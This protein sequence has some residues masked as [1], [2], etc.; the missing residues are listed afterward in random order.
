MIATPEVPIWRERVTAAGVVMCAGALTRASKR[1]LSCGIPP[2]CRGAGGVMAATSWPRVSVQGRLPMRRHGGVLCSRS[3]IAL[4]MAL[5]LICQPRRNRSVR[6]HQLKVAEAARPTRRCLRA[7]ALVEYRPEGGDS[8]TTSVALVHV[9]LGHLASLRGSCTETAHSWCM[10]DPRNSQ[11]GA[12]RDFEG[13]R[14]GDPRFIYQPHLLLEG[15]AQHVGSGFAP[16]N[17]CSGHRPAFFIALSPWM[18]TRMA[19]SMVR[20]SS[21]PVCSR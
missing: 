1:T 4:E 17:P 11:T 15:A 21:L 18:P 6:V 12:P 5:R 13:G 19:S 14:T 9:A 3:V 16:D 20:G 7:Q 8:F 2:S 10:P